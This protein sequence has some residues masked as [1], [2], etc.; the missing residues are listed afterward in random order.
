[1]IKENKDE[2]EKNFKVI[3][4]SMIETSSMFKC[5]KNIEQEIFNEK[6]FDIAGFQELL[7]IKERYALNP[8]DEDTKMIIANFKKNIYILK[9]KFDKQQKIINIIKKVKK[10][11]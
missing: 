3:D 11:L 10:S 4:L 1:L 2:L 7:H 9:N 5:L 6:E 8:N